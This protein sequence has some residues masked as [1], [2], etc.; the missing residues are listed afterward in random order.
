MP[1]LQR[2]ILGLV[3][4]YN[5][6]KFGKQGYRTAIL[7]SYQFNVVHW[8]DLNAHLFLEIASRT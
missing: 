4:D 6:F 3:G 1:R 2:A 7:P 8:L 5:I